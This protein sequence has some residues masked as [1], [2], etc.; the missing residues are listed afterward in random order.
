MGY[1]EA[2]AASSFATDSQG[3]RLFYPWG[4]L[5]KGYVIPTDDDYRRLQTTL[6]RTYQILIPTMILLIVLAHRWM[7]LVPFGPVLLFLFSYP[8]WVRRVTSGWSRS[9]ERISLRQQIANQAQY[10]SRSFLWPFLIFSLA[11]VAGGVGMIM[12]QHNWQVGVAPILFFGFGA[13]LFS[14]ML[15]SRRRIQNQRGIVRR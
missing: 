10:Q 9:A 4:V 14:W 15:I 8:I 5:G 7:P 1:F 3:R 12:E 2:I 6:V 13:V 11:F